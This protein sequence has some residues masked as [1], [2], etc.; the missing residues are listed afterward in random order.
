MRRWK[1]NEVKYLRQ[2]YG[3]EPIEEIATALDRSAESVRQYASRLGLRSSRPHRLA[4]DV[5]KIKFYIYEGLHPTE[6]ARKLNTS[7]K[8]IYN[9][10]KYGRQYD[11][12]DY[13]VLLANANK[14]GRIPRAKRKNDV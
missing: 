9:R 2:H 12:F 6:I 10:V 11:A 8:A 14:V 4:Q 1:T 5:D 13:R 3:F 7:T